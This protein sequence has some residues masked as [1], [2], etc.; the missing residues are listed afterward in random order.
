MANHVTIGGERVECSETFEVQI[1]EDPKT[2]ERLAACPTC[3]EV[4]RAWTSQGAAEALCAHM[5]RVH[6]VPPAE[7]NA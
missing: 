7:G 3:G 2:G 1:E 5:N 4:A 6:W